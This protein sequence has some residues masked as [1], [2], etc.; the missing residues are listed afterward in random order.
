M[1]ICDNTF[2]LFLAKRRDNDDGNK[3]KLATFGKAVTM[4]Y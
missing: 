1:N 4:C 2:C 3:S